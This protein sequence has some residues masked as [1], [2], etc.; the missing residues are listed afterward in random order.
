MTR[1]TLIA[2][3]EL[4]GY[5]MSPLGYVIIAALLLLNGVA[6]NGLAMD[7]EKLSYDVLQTFFFYSCGFVVVAGVLFSMRLFAEE[8]QTGTMLLLQTSPASEVE[9]VLGKF[10]GGYTF[11]GLFIALT[12]YMPLLVLVNGRVT[13]GHLAVGYLGLYL[14]AAVSIGLGTLASALAKNQLLAAIIGGV[15]TVAFFLAW[16]IARRVD[17]PLGD[18]IG[19]LDLF[20]KHFRSLSRGVLKLSTVVYYLSLTYA[21]LVGAVAVLSARRWRA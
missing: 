14:L 21:S 9:L 4:V 5:L 7:G 3:R 12:G 16:V 6:F 13:W 18:A 20:D 17:G 8:K 11:L 1:I 2:R 10:L 15:L 19:Y